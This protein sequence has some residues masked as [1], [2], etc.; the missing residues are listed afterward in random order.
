MNRKRG[1]GPLCRPPKRQAIPL[2]Q[3]LSWLRIGEELSGSC[4]SPF[5]TDLILNQLC[6]NPRTALP[7]PEKSSAPTRPRKFYGVWS[8][9]PLRA[10]GARALPEPPPA[11]ST[12]PLGRSVIVWWRRGYFIAP[13][14]T[15]EFP[16]KL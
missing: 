3:I 16:E 10:L 14:S 6:K 7:E 2:T 5:R 15:Q 9:A 13:V 11:T 4:Q 12:W 1:L 8:S